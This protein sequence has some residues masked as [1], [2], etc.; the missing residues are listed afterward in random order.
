[1][2]KLSRKICSIF[3]YFEKCLTLINAFLSG[4]NLKENVNFNQKM[5]GDDNVLAML[6]RW[7]YDK[8]I[9]FIRGKKI[10]V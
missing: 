10:D 9:K 3:K 1:M 7:S 6:N 4:Y 2:L 8:D 5:L